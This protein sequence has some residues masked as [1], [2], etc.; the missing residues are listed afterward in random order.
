MGIRLRGHGCSSLGSSLEMSVV[1]EEDLTGKSLYVLGVVRK[2]SVILT[3]LSP[4]FRNFCVLRVLSHKNNNSKLRRSED[5]FD[6]D[7]TLLKYF[8]LNELKSFPG[9]GGGRLLLELIFQIFKFSLPLLS[10]P[11][12]YLIILQPLK[13]RKEKLLRPTQGFL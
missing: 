11:D 8:H 7:Q 5:F 1:D 10:L 13:S 4:S 2:E 6:E 12:S 3:L 9:G